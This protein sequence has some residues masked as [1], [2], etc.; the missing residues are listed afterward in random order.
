MLELTGARVE[1]GVLEPAT[2]LWA[3][4]GREEAFSC[5]GSEG[6]SSVSHPGPS[7]VFG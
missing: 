2:S 3:A 4:A 5:K 6:N 7:A 1:E